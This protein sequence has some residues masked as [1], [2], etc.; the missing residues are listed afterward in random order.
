VALTEIDRRLHASYPNRLGNPALMG[1][2]MGAF[3]S[4][5]VAATG[6][7]NQYCVVT[8]GRVLRFLEGK[9]GV[10]EVRIAPVTN[11]L[12]LIQ[13]D[14]YVAI[15][16]PVRLMYGIAKLD[17]FYRAPLKWR[18]TNR[19]DNI[20]NTF[21]KVAALSKDK[22]TPQT[23]LPFSAIESKFLI[24]LTFR[25][26]LRDVIYTSQQRHNQGVLHHTIWN[27]RRE[28]VYQEI[29]RYSYRDY[30]EKFVIPYYQSRGMAL[31][32]ETLEKAGD[33]RTYDAS[34]HANLDI[35][36]ICNENDFLLADED[37]TWLHATFGPEHL[38]VFP[39][40][41]HLGNL[42]NP[43]VQK[44]ILA[45]LTPMRPPDPKPEEPSKNLTP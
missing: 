33:L 40:G 21:L 28:P 19:T 25:F 26:I 41:G 6:P 23:S 2:S 31:P 36:V 7:T 8:K 17:E 10:K 3:E 18:A 27:W 5:F 39:Q 35:R 22:L 42:S 15:S 44:A 12:P 34:L 37:L 16:P 20:E 43:K 32:A 13:F 45:A 14:R 9:Q 30:F 24:G 38:T 4:L 1:Y 29:L 11:Q